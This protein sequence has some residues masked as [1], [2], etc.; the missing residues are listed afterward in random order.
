MNI[1]HAR[2]DAP[3]FI[4]RL[5]PSLEH[6]ADSPG[7]YIYTTKRTIVTLAS[8]LP[9]DSGA[10]SGGINSRTMISFMC[11]TVDVATA[12]SCGL[13][14]HIE[15]DEGVNVIH[16]VECGA[17]FWVPSSPKFAVDGFGSSV[18]WQE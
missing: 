16:A 1:N 2:P 14:G 5:M 3:D 18:A 12:S 6:S 4:T 7:L 17:R 8:A 10:R 11:G 13:F 15:I 9:S